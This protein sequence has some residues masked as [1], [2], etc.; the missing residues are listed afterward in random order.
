MAMKYRK[1]LCIE[2]R[3]QRGFAIFETPQVG[4]L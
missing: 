4:M 3:Q 1:P 2:K